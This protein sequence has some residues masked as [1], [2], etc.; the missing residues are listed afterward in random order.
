[1]TIS[2]EAIK[3]ALSAL[4]DP[5]TGTDYVS[6][7]MFKSA[8]TDEN[9]NVKVFIELG[10]PAKHRA[11]AVGQAVGEAVRAAGAASVEVSV[12]QTSSRTR[13]RARFASCPASRISLR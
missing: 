6:G 10:Y 5:V 1:M 3:S 8:E 11:E 12:T 4:I 13:C 2:T 9:G 7:K